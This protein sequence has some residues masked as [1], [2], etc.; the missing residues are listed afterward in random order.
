MTIASI[1]SAI[2]LNF[3]S[4]GA[5]KYPWGM[6][7]FEKLFGNQVEAFLKKLVK[8]TKP[9]MIMVC[10][11]Y[12]LDENPNAKSWAGTTLGALRY[13]S[14]PHLLQH[15]VKTLFERATKSIKIPGV[16]VVPVPM[17]E[18]LNGKCT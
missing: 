11:L 18:T 5:W 7:H 2:A 8:K 13:N 1:V 14:K 17:F 6:G 15:L 3:V 10:M 16:K 9:K 4:F 12:Y